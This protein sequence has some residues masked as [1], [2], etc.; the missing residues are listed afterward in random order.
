[1]VPR[2]FENK[3]IWITGATS[4]IG[5]SFFNAFSVKNNITLIISARRKTVL[6][7]MKAKATFSE[8]VYVQPMD[9]SDSDSIRSGC[10][11]VLANHQI[12]VLFLNAGVAQR[13][14]TRNTT[15][16]TA[17]RIIQTDL[18][19][20]ILQAKLVLPSMLKS[21]SGHFVVT[22][23][24]A[25]K[26]GTT[27]RTAYC[28]AKHGIIGFFD[29]LRSEESKNGISVTIM[30]PGYIKTEVSE[31][32]L[33]HEGTRFGAVDKTIAK[34]MDVDV[35]VRKALPKIAR[36]RAEFAI[37]GIECLIIPIKR[38]SPWF[39]RKLMPYMKP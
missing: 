39:V 32:A 38:I 33:V 27:Y 21:K 15:Y 7:T 13:S 36:R 6:E 28:A 22:A 11:E 19:G 14:L 25:G 34:A 8:N 24:V 5:L 4:G 9:L 30:T 3:T 1:M 29:G 35:Y 23:S 16:E 31:N 2:Y 26:V 37:G 18:L 17:E 12:D 20:Q 10:A